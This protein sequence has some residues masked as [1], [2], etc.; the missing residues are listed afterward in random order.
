VSHELRTPITIIRGFAQ[1]LERSI[2]T[3]DVSA[4]KRRLGIIQRQV[5]S[6][7]ELIHELLDLSRIQT[8]HFACHPTR[9][10]YRT[11]VETVLDD[12][13]A[14][15]PERHL[16]FISP[17]EVRVWADAV[18]LRQVIVNL[19]DNALEHG[20][21]ETPVTVE[22]EQDGDRVVTY[23]CDR[24][25]ALPLEER[26]RVFERFYRVSPEPIQ[27][28][29]SLGLGLFISRAIVEA[30]GGSIWIVDADRSTFAFSLRTSATPVASPEA[31]GNYGS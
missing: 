8:G 10:D 3:G 5:D 25:P 6:L 20:P 18:R 13:A 16:E 22:L 9:I 30:H 21:S 14:L 27:Y 29:G 24:G 28:G 7:T 19:I 12:L 31:G 2:D 11:L 17:S 4:T 1:V 26:D 15:H 23:V